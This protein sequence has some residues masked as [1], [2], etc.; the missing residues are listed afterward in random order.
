MNL[1]EKALLVKFS[2]SQW[3]ARKFDKKVSDEIDQAHHAHDASRFNKILLGKEAL[4]KGQKASNE[5]RT[6][7][8]QQ[9]LPWND[10]GWRILPSAN[11]LPFTMEMQKK[12][13]TIQL[14]DQEFIDRYPDYKE[15]A[16]ARLNSLFDSKDYPDPQDVLKKF[17][18]SILFQPIPDSQDFRTSQEIS[19]A[20][21]DQ[22]GK[23]LDE[24]VKSATQEAIKDLWGRLYN[25]VHHVADRLSDPE[26]IFRDSLINNI[27]DLCD[28][29]PRL[30]LTADPNLEAM[31]QEVK[32]RL[33]KYQPEDL[34]PKD[35][36]K[37][38]DKATKTQAREETKREAEKILKT[39]EAYF[40]P[41]N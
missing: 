17:E 27:I 16:K 15:E 21:L 30:N 6:F 13:N 1:K 35:T 14:A 37:P 33:T 9:T 26:A 41:N 25:A 39:M 38:I 34:R 5:A 18:T 32:D 28:L 11:Y 7:V 23:D 20:D 24:R 19:Q 4:E 40:S 31:R 22:M 36:D 3:S 10:E 8:Y 29:L 2:R 12:I